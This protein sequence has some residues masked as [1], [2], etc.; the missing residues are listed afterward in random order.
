MKLL[1]VH[2]LQFSFKTYAGEVQAVRGVSFSLNVG[3]ALGIVGESGCG[4][5][6]TAKSIV[7]L[8]PTRNGIYKSGTIMFDN[9]DILS[10]S[11]QEMQI[12]RARDIR[13]IFQDPMTSLNPT[14]RVGRQIMEG[15]KVAYPNMKKEEAKKR[16]LDILYSTGIPNTEERF[17]QYP[18]Q[19]SGGMRQRAMIALAM[20]VKPKLLICDEPTTAL[21]VTI[22]A[23]ILDLIKEQQEKTKTGIILIT[24]DLGVVANIAK[25]IAVMY[26]GKIVEYGSAQ[27][28]FYNCMHPYT[29]GV[30]QSI[31]PKDADINKPLVPIKGTPPDL[32]KPPKGCSFTARCPYAMKAC[33]EMPPPVYMA[34]ENHSVAC[35]RYH[36]NAPKIINPITQREVQ[37]CPT[38]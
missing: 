36:P 6:V 24:H 8:N 9:K 7:R 11:K 2:D 14:M 12:I 10:L 3:E 34:D 18:H 25:N 31:P 26:A 38:K 17:K 5:S 28:I 32:L 20:V 22:Q 23:Q 4:K 35:W 13:M 37:L 1:D 27:D 16:T 29:W 30:L 33:K 19:F 21:D 15:F